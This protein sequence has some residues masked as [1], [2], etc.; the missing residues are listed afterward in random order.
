MACSVYCMLHGVFVAAVLSGASA[1]GG[2]PLFVMLLRARF[3]LLRRPSYDVVLL[4]SLKKALFLCETPCCLT[5]E[6]GTIVFANKSFLEWLGYAPQSLYGV[7]VLTLLESPPES[8]GTLRHHPFY[9]KD[10]QGKSVSTTITHAASLAYAHIVCLF[11]S[12]EEKKDAKGATL[13]LDLLPIPA[14]FLDE[15]GGVK[16]M[17]VLLRKKLKDVRGD[18]PALSQWIAERDKILF[19]KTLKDLRK[20]RSSQDPLLISFRNNE[21]QRVLAFL[22]HIGSEASTESFL[23]IFD[24]MV[25][26]K[27]LHAK[28][29]ADPHRLQLLGQL[30]SGIV[31]D[32][33]N[34]LTG[35]IG[36]CDLLV[37]KQP[38]ESSLRDILQIKQNAMRAARLIQQLLSFS[39]ASPPQEAPLDVKA[40]IQGLSSLIRRM[41][42]PKI[43]LSVQQQT[44]LRLVFG[45]QGQLEQALLNLAINAR[46]A[47]PQGGSLMFSLRRM[48]VKTPTQ[49]S[50]GMLSPQH[51]TVIDVSDTG[52]GIPEEYLT[53]IFDPFFSTKD[54]GQGTGLGLSN[55]LQVMEAFRGGISVKTKSKK[56]TTFSL[57]FPE[58]EGGAAIP[59]ISVSSSSPSVN[60]RTA[61]LK[62]LLVEDEDAVRLFASRALREKGH[63]VIEAR[64]GQQALQLADKHR[65]I[66]VVV[67]DVMMPGVDGP[68]LAAA[69]RKRD[70]EIKIL[71]VSGYPEDEVRA[72]IPHE[73]SGL[74]FLRK[75]FT[76]NEL[77][78]EIEKFSA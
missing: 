70:G 47:M 36:F 34:L 21:S 74:Y 48:H 76:L 71:F 6:E 44:P 50:R 9:V 72:Q 58:Y 11:F 54:P 17:N 31:H 18:V 63:E 13:S 23:A 12:R 29:A 3:A 25:E 39:K 19:A 41:I 60:A 42:G 20:A 55:V 27:L 73:T 66:S 33:N 28:E 64:D 59:V 15:R 24:T 22:K 65:N 51:Y 35:I 61:A 2:I 26:E 30:A 4:A 62:I 43:F 7:D 53:R 56:G 37:P 69:M 49:V 1:I 32:F 14:A 57:Y 52:V 5:S 38:E 77:V 68:S 67:T 8:F 46:D 16:D 75:P 45:D 78:H 10:V 40:C